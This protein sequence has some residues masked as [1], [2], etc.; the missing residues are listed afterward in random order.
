MN[1]LRVA[2]LI[3]A[4]L[5]SG[6]AFAADQ[7][8]DKTKKASLED[9]LKALD[10]DNAAPAAASREKLYAVQT[11]Y[12]PL[13]FKNE[14]TLGGASNLTPDSFLTT[15][16]VEIGYHFHFNDRWSASVDQAW[17]NNT[18][19]SDTNNL[20]TT[21]GALPNVPYATS[22]TDLMAEYN[23]FYGKFRWSAETVSYFDQYLAIGPGMVEQNTG[24]TAAAVADAG[25]A[26][27]LGKWGSARLGLKD[28]YYREQYASGAQF[29]QNIHAHMDFGYLF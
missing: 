7:A 21:D 3:G 28:Y 29:T 10:A 1:H 14:F 16:Q 17:V 26:F 23:V 12:L 11:R 6:A 20:R 13:H 27:W 25:F 19:K 4:I 8:P 9:Q 15:Q 2:A 5:L 24:A 18:F 22:R